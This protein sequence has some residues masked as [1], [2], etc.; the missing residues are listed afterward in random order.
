[1]VI[2]YRPGDAE[3]AGGSVENASNTPVNCPDVC[4]HDAKRAR[5]TGRRGNARATNDALKRA[6][7][8]ILMPFKVGVANHERG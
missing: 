6:T 1:V 5:K 8:R 7:V 3:K 4:V 2:R